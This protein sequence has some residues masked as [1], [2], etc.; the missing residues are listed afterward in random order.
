MTLTYALVILCFIL[1]MINSF[2]IWRMSKIIRFSLGLCMDDN[3]QQITKHSIL[4]R[5]S[6]TAL[7]PEMALASAL[8]MVS[9]IA[10]ERARSEP[11][12]SESRALEL[13]SLLDTYG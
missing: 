7:S 13:Q 2:T 11:L 9:Q 4:Q 3:L 6:S 12:D 10:E 5:L 8:T 1:A